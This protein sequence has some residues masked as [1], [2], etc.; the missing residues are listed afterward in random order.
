MSN[1]GYISV[2]KLIE[3]ANNHVAG[4]DANDI[5]RFPR[6]DVEKI[7]HAKWILVKDAGRM[8]TKE[9]KML[10]F[11]CSK[12]KRKIEIVDAYQ[13][14]LSIMYPYCHCGARMDGGKE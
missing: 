7:R 2:D 5:A 6:A 1:L 10:E 3:F 14:Y 4:I 11:A 8:L 12:C 13:D 9:H